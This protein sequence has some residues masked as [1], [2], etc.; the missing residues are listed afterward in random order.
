MSADGPAN[1]VTVLGATGE[2]GIVPRLLEVIDTLSSPV[3]VVIALVDCLAELGG[4][5][6]R[7]ALEEMH[8]REGLHPEVVEEIGVALQI[9]ESR[10]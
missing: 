9:I 6:S 1:I 8:E 5:T 3:D 7:K 10:R 2:R 4:E